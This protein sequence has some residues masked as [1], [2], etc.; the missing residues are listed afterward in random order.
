MQSTLHVVSLVRFLDRGQAVLK[1]C[2]RQKS[3]CGLRLIGNHT[4]VLKCSY[5]VFALLNHYDE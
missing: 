3:R 2:K 1:P 4:V 5:G